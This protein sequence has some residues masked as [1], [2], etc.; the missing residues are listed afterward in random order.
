MH[1]SSLFPRLRGLYPILDLE[2]LEREQLD[3]IALGEALLSIGVPVLQVRAKRAG[4]SRTLEV[5]QALEPATRQTG[6]WLINNDRADLALCAGATGV[7]VG[8]EDLS[9]PDVRRF[10][11]K[12]RVGLSTHDLAE[13]ERGLALGPDYIAYGPVFPTASKE[14]PDPVVGVEGLRRA[15]VLTRR[16]GVPLVAIGGIDLAGAAEL[17]TVADM[18]AVIGALFAEGRSLSQVTRHARALHE[19]LVW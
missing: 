17:S 4:A 9:L 13:L 7:H 3:P 15:S 10:A 8:Q 6:A 19:A 12:L 1:A 5:L 2:R 16:A 18:A 14:N 11:P